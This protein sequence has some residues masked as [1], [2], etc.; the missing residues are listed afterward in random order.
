[1]YA[2]PESNTSHWHVP[3]PGENYI[4]VSMFAWHKSIKWT[5]LTPWY[6]QAQ[7]SPSIP[8]VQKHYN[9]WLEN[10]VSDNWLIK[11]HHNTTTERVEHSWKFNFQITLDNTQTTLHH[12][13]KVYQSTDPEFAGRWGPQFLLLEHAQA[14]Q[15]ITESGN[16]TF[17][18]DSPLSTAVWTWFEG[19]KSIQ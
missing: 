14:H 19:H 13:W 18:V 11:I 10:A 7:K 16:P 9:E 6:L 15:R 1:M 17:G 12:D 5:N 3:I 8:A 4:T 2:E